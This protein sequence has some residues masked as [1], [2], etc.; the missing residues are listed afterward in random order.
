MRQAHA[1]S[2][3]TG[4]G[5]DQQRETQ[6]QCFAAQSFVA[7]VIAQVSGGRR[8]PGGDHAPLGARL[9][10]HRGNG[11]GRRADEDQAG[12]GAG[13]GEGR[14]FA[15]K[16][17]TGMHGLRAAALCRGQQGRDVA[18][19]LRRRRRADAHGLVGHSDMGRIG[20]D[21]GID[22]DRAVTQ[23]ARRAH[24]AAGDLSPIGD[25]YLAK[26]HERGSVPSSLEMMPSMISS[27]PPPIDTRRP[28]RQARDT[29]LSQV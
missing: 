12:V 4:H 27:A 2:A 16:A 20:I 3:T 15:E 28:S 10:A 7:L 5:L 24:D 22:G 11:V 21:I 17:V 9:V 19:G 29:G 1:A 25:E 26:A 13:P 14:V 23:R 8:H 6:G 18:I